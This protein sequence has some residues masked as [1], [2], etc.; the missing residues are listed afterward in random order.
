MEGDFTL[1]LSRFA[2]LDVFD[3]FGKIYFQNIFNFFDLGGLEF[4]TAFQVEKDR[5][6]GA[7]AEDVSLRIYYYLGGDADLLLLTGH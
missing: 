3:V 6:S 5:G 1:D 2:R 4:Q 7:V